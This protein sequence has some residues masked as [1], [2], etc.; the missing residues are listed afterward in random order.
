MLSIGPDKLAPMTRLAYVL[1]ACAAVT[2]A[3]TGARSSVEDRAQQIEAQVWSPYCPGR[4]L[5]DCTT[6][7]ARQLRSQI[8]DR[9]E[10]GQTSDQVLDWIRRNHGAEALARPDTN[11]LGLAMWLVP[12]ALFV[13]G[14]I[15]VA[16][17]IR[18]WSVRSARPAKP[19]A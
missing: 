7:Q 11:G 19:T 8:S 14:G 13:A 12:A 3:C 5:I 17:L 10:H 9:L 6:Q 15:I 1:L 16:R 2:T 4:L 18:K